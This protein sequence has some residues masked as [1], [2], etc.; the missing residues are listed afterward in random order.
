MLA[1][2]E[3]TVFEKQPIAG[4]TAFRAVARYTYT[5]DNRKLQ[6]EV[7]TDVVPDM[8]PSDDVMHEDLVRVINEKLCAEYPYADI[9]RIE[10]VSA[11]TA[12]TPLAKKVLEVIEELRG[13]QED[14]SDVPESWP[15]VVQQFHDRF[16]EQNAW[17]KEEEGSGMTEKL[18]MPANIVEYFRRIV[19]KFSDRAYM[20]GWQQGRIKGTMVTKQLVKTEIE[21]LI[22][23]VELSLSL[24]ES[25]QN[26]RKE[27]LNKV[28][29][30]VLRL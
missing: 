7:S 27:A 22:Q 21:R 26:T 23:N 20:T 5:I 17:T 4:R 2:K 14:F 8:A 10:P 24:S 13:Q 11:S 30:F 9:E 1:T 16:I 18:V 3:T 25:E 15:Q 28:L 12:A 6:C 29:E 19:H